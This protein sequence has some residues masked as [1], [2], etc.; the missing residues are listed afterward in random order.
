MLLRWRGCAA[1]ILS[2]IACSGKSVAER[3]AEHD[4]VRVSWEQTTRFTGEEWIARAI[5]D[6]F[7]SRTL[8]RASEELQSEE[9][10]LR[11]DSVPEQQRAAL[12]ESLGAARALAD[13]LA[14][15]VGARDRVWVANLV[16][17]SPRAN[18]DSLLRRA[19]LR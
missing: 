18:A 15:A 12:R 3:I 5:P 8:A 7:A 11:K 17:N 2:V 10:A 1:L 4:R 16:R 13:S 6:A 14:R 9:E 19:A